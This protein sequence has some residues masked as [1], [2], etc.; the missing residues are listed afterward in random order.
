MLS[1]SP[2]LALRFPLGGWDG[3]AHAIRVGRGSRRIPRHCF[4]PS[5]PPGVRVAAQDTCGT[6]QSK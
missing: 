4:N 2:L 5:R 1:C 3:D 6:P